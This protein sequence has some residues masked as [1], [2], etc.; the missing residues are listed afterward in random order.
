MPDPGVGVVSGQPGSSMPATTRLQG[1]HEKPPPS[2]GSSVSSFEVVK[3]SGVEKAV[4][5]AAAAAA[6]LKE[7]AEGQP[8][9]KG[10]LYKWTNYIKG[11]QKRWFVLANGLLH[12]YR[13]Q[14]EMA[15]TC[16]GSISL[17]NGHIYTED[18]CNFVVS[19]AGGTQTY[20]LRAAS[21]VERQHWVT[22]L[23]LA[24][25][26]ALQRMVSEDDRD[27]DTEDGEAV[28]G[29]DIDKQEL[30]NVVK[31]L[32]SKLEDLRTCHL[33]V[34][35]HRHAL[36]HSL[37]E[38]EVSGSASGQSISGSK[39]S[40]STK[41]LGI[42]IKTVNERATLLN[43]TCNAMINASAEFLEQC[44]S[45]GKRWHRILE[46]EREIRQHLEDMVQQ[47]AKQHSHLEAMVK[48]EYKDHHN[49]STVHMNSIPQVSEDSNK[50]EKK[51]LIYRTG[52]ALGSPSASIPMIAGRSVSSTYSGTGSDDDD[53]E[54]ALDT[55][56]IC[57]NVPV[58][59]SRR[60]TSSEESV[61][62][63]SCQDEDGSLS[64]DEAT[65]VSIT[66]SGD[67]PD[68]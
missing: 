66:K 50:E 14:A 25:T 54:D 65:Q 13:N 29:G 23:E 45:N 24:K 32:S 43:I 30:T 17:H 19:N 48:K 52:S 39:E 36:Q 46:S 2:P 59:P 42:K 51:E 57:F 56:A 40:I 12:Y 5:A 28:P 62:A 58:P 53:F 44:Q 8:E 27:I 31:F 47:L 15:R 55:P 16:R 3:P 41:D 34:D 7:G 49:T 64:D 33:L 6:P 4:A 10:W 37:G 1:A 67:F 22:V 63:K 38:L 18:S 20:H 26:K 61:G 9:T 35:K 68:L 11:Y 60:R 21:E